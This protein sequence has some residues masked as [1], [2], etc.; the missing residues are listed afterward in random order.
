MWRG[1]WLAGLPLTPLAL[2]Y[3]IG[4][5]VYVFLYRS[6]LKLP[7]KPHSPVVRV[8]NLVAGGTGKSPFV[9]WLARALRS[10]G[11]HVVLGL[12]GY[13]SPAQHSA[14][15]APEGALD[16]AEWGDEPAMA[17]WILPDVPMIVGR[18][19]VRAAE[20]CNEE[21]PR[22]VLLMDDGH[23]HLR[24][25][26]DVSLVIDVRPSNPFVFPAGPFREPRSVGLKRASR[27]LRYGED[28]VAR[29]LRFL[30]GERREVERPVSAH[31]VSSV[32][33]PERF[34]DSL[35]AAGVSL[36]KRVIKT[37]HDP[38]DSPRLFD[39][40]SDGDFVVVTAKDYVKLRR[41]EDAGSVRLV[42]ADYAVEG[43]DEV[44]LLNW[45]EAKIGKA[46]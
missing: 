22:S 45:L 11:W 17:R 15:L 29:G 33:R 31:V 37:D 23:Q 30:D 14:A 8:G 5:R 7:A 39:G 42:V 2:A 43:I 13:G 44:E 32:A 34:L 1:H 26:T 12:S 20:I 41:R 25:E 24:L 18:D 21:F 19:R 4:W 16:A 46:P 6:E 35:L 27:V 38:L 9:L 10:R 3:S 40:M 28:I 36:K